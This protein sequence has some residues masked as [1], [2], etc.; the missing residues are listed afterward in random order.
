MISEMLALVVDSRAVLTDSG[1]LQKE[2]YFLGVPCITL[3]D[4]TEWRGTLAGGWNRLVGADPARLRAAVG[5]L[6]DERGPRDVERFGG[7]HAAERV[8]AELE[9]L[10]A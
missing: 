3:R 9:S 6:D 8:V 7:G 10:L 5:A 4:E 2:A 1:G